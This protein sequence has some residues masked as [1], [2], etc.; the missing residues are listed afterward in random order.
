MLDLLH[1]LG[2]IHAVDRGRKSVDDASKAEG[3]GAARSGK[4]NTM[5]AATDGD[6]TTVQDEIGP[7]PDA[8]TDEGD[9]GL[10]SAVVVP[11]STQG[12]GIVGRRCPFVSPP[13][14]F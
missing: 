1:E 13:S 9:G 5:T 4:T 3:G 11:P 12:G 6:G 10:S 8:A 2:V 14:E 7:S